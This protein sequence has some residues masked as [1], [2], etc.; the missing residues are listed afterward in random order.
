[1]IGWIYCRE[2]LSY[3]QET[4]VEIYA[5]PSPLP[6]PFDASLIEP[7]SQHT[8]YLGGATLALDILNN[9]L[10]KSTVL[11]THGA[12][13]CL[14]GDPLGRV[15][16]SG[17]L[18][19][20]VDLLE[21]ETLCLGDEEVGVDEGAGAKTTPDEED[22]RPQVA[23]ILVDHVRCDGS[24]D[25]VPEPVGGGRESDT[26]GADGEREDLTNENPCARTPSG[27]KEED[28]DGNEGDLG[29]DSG[30]VVGDWVTSSVEVGVVESNSHTNDGDEELADQHAEGTPEEKRTTA[31]LLHGVEGDGCR[32]DVNESEDER[33]DEGVADST[34]RLEERCGEIENEVDS[35][36]LLH[37]LERGSENGLAEVGVGLEDGTGEAVSPRADP[38]GVGD[39]LTFVLGV[40]DNLGKLGLDVL[41]VSG[42]SSK[43]GESTT[44][45]L[46]TTLLDEVARGLGEE[47][48]T[49]GEDDGPSKLNGNGNAVG[50]SV[51]AVLGS[52][53]NNGS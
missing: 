33:D 37:H 52:I 31:D 32:A 42:L 38:V 4:N 35:S 5:T 29:V 23:L 8:F 20:A 21:G 50:T 46:N 7:E 13:E 34:G 22:G 12:G 41:G 27:S 6:N 19:H 15:P 2:T 25:A 18:H 48:D 28:E 49:G 30:D 3:V 17:L 9:V 14:V 36:P 26:T 16:G 51:G 11:E 47:E 43:A 53:C 10:I 39:N 1:V 44:G 40:G 24:N 45:S